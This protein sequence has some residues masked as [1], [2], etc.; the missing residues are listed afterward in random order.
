MRGAVEHAVRPR[1]GLKNVKYHEV[2]NMAIT[3][4]ITLPFRGSHTPR[5]CMLRSVAAVWYSSPNK[6][7]DVDKEMRGCR[8]EGRPVL[9]PFVDG[10]GT[11]DS[12]E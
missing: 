6:N 9:F 3:E 11:E 12:D 1:E 4:T 10:G 7:L 5:T 2:V 8:M